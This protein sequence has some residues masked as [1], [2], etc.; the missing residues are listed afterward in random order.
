MSAAEFSR[1]T[2]ERFARPPFAEIDVPPRL[3]EADR[4]SHVVIL[5]NFRDAILDGAP[6]LAPAEEA[7]RSLEIGNAMLLS[8]LLGRAVD[9]P[10]DAELMERELQRLAAR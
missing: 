6:L 9:L 2:R 7:I 4:E 3:A 8:G 5:E 10:I 1:T